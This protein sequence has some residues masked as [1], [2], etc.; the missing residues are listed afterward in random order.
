MTPALQQEVSACIL[1]PT[2]HRVFAGGGG[3]L[4]HPASVMHLTAL[5]PHP[6]SSEE[7][8]KTFRSH[9]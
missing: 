7:K 3:H 6:H 1:A 4:A 9:E 2:K 8:G 5:S